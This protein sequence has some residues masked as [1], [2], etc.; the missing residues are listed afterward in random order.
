LKEQENYIIWKR[1]IQDIIITRRLGY[2]IIKDHVVPL[3][4]NKVF[5]GLYPGLT[6]ETSIKQTYFKKPA[7][8][9]NSC[10]IVLDI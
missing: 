2:Y 10:N 6:E 7:E 8:F 4:E 1:I 9:L 3:L 5:A